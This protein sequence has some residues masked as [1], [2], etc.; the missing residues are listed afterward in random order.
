MKCLQQVVYVNESSNNKPA[1]FEN[2]KNKTKFGFII[3]ECIRKISP[4]D[5]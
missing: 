5:F 3:M 1:D 4:K 2:Y